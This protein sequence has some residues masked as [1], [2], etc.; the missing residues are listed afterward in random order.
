MRPPVCYVVLCDVFVIHVAFAEQNSAVTIC[1]ACEVEAQT[2]ARREAWRKKLRCSMQSIP[3][4]RG[5]VKQLEV[6]GPDDLRHE[7]S[8]HRTDNFTIVEYFS[9]KNTCRTPAVCQAFSSTSVLSCPA[10]SL[11]LFGSRH[12]SVV[13]IFATFH[14]APSQAPHTSCEGRDLPSSRGADS[15][16]VGTSSSPTEGHAVVDSSVVR[17]AGLRWQ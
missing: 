12:A 10:S 3:P 6:P 9:L 11:V 14:T 1:V 5:A 13:F 16:L 17:S 2:K 7:S 15:S 4:A 8:S